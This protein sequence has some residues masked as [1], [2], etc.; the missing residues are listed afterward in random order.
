M[1]AGHDEEEYLYAMF[2][3]C[4]SDAFPA[5]RWDGAALLREIE[6]FESD[7]RR[8]PVG[9]LGRSSPYPRLLP[10]S[11]LLRIRE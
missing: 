8:R 10:L 1:D 11:V 5:Q 4:L 7:R 9:N 3:T 2:K 6:A